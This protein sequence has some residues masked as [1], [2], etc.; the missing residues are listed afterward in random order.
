[1]VDLASDLNLLEKTGAFY[2][3]DGELIGQGRER[4]IEWLRAHPVEMERLAVKVLA[5]LKPVEAAATAEA[6]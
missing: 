1:M 5:T 2:R 6:A 4:A 3:L